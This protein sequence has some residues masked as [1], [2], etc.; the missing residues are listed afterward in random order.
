MCTGESSF[1][2]ALTIGFAAEPS[3]DLGHCLFVVL[4]TCV[5]CLP[6]AV[7]VLRPRESGRNAASPGQSA[8]HQ[9][10]YTRY[11]ISGF[12]LKVDSS[13]VYVRVRV[14]VRVFLRY[15]EYINDCVN[16]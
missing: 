14:R 11:C 8:C 12:N 6:T 15:G 13:C 7:A 2:H 1:E 16:L 4:P 5:I 10:A 9:W 3:H